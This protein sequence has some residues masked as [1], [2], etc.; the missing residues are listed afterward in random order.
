[1]WLL[2]TSVTSVPT[3]V[4]VYPGV[5]HGFGVFPTLSATKKSGDDLVKGI[6]WLLRCA[7]N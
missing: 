4:D 5:P 7:D 3:K 2:L 6:E 1:M